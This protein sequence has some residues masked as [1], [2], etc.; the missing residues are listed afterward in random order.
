MY[1]AFAAAVYLLS[2]M[3]MD[4][5]RI[6]LIAALILGFFPW[7]ETVFRIYNTSYEQMRTQLLVLLQVLCTGVSSGYSIEKSLTLVRPVIEHTFGRRSPLIKP[8]SAM[9]NKLR[10]H[11]DSERVLSEFAEDIRFPETIPVF[12]AL[13]ISGR[14]GSSSLAILRSSCQMLSEMNAVHNDINAENAGKNAEACML[15]IMPFAITFAL[16]NMNSNYL[17]EA[18]NSGAGKILMGVAFVLCIIAAALLFRFMTHASKAPRNKIPDADLAP[19]PSTP[20]A[21]FLTRI[22]P[23]SFTARRHTL[24]CELSVNPRLYY[25]HYIRKQLVTITLSG[26]LVFFIASALDKPRILAIASMVLMYVLNVS[27]IRSKVNLKH[28]DLMR[29]IPLFLCLISTLL[30]AGLQL[31]KAI[32][33]CSKA[34]DERGAISYEINAMRAGILSGMPASDAVESFSIRTQI[35][36]AQA[37][38]LLIARYGRL[39]TSEVLN[40]LSLQASACWNLCRNAARKKQERESLGM[41]LPMTLDFVCVLIVAVT[42]AIISMAI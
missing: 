7:K 11:M 22:L 41:L 13:S 38:L 32:E 4:S 18:K 36:E 10:M 17:E 39:G 6:R 35:P 15:C 12:H 21:D 1:P 34:F 9:E 37:A 30:E 33:I 23:A 40:L 5:V 20:I 2:S 19:D 31:P 8:L 25:E 14:I 42:P 16:N 29:D 27:E 28:E 26:I 3:F 24:F